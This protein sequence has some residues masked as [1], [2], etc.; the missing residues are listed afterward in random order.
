MGPHGVTNPVCEL[1]VRPGGGI[2]I[3]MRGPDGTV[4]PMTGVYREEAGWTQS[5]ERLEAHLASGTLF[6]SAT[7]RDRVVE[8]FGAIEGLNQTLTRLEEYVP[9]CS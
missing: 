6:E 5:L 4:Y 7:E 9:S 1:A 3:D 8:K 2:H